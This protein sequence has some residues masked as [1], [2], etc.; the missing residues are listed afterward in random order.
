MNFPASSQTESISITV[1]DMHMQK[2]RVCSRSRTVAQTPARMSI[3]ECRSV[4]E[5]LLHTL[6]PLI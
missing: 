2:R 3:A 4:Q 6:P 5:V 1:H